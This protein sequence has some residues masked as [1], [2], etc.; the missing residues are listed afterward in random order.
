[1]AF[2]FV[3]CGLTSPG[4]YT[5]VGT[6][7]SGTGGSAGGGAS[8]GV[9]F[10]TNGSSPFGSG[11]FSGGGGGTTIPGSINGGGGASSGG[12]GGGASGSNT[13]T[14]NTG[15][16]APTDANGDPL[17]TFLQGSAITELANS[18]MCDGFPQ[19]SHFYATVSCPA[20]PNGELYIA[21]GAG[22][23]CQQGINGQGGGVLLTVRPVTNSQNQ[24]IG[25][26][27]DCCSYNQGQ[28]SGISYGNSSGPAWV[29]CALSR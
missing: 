6:L 17:S 10:N 7:G 5:G 4:G 16:S 25:A 21:T 19:M 13:G 18:S 26:Y 14:V 8:Q 27:I 9:A 23:D 3:A 22:A 29:Q 1:M 20:G 2:S 28:A 15:S 24:A 11:A 12:G